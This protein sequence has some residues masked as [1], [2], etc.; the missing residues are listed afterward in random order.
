MFVIIKRS[1]RTKTYQHA[2]MAMLRKFTE[3]R[4]LGAVPLSRSI[5]LA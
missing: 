3:G 5:S 1:K 4:K 2:K